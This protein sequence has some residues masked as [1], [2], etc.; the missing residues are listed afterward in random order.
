[1]LI[2]YEN[3]VETLIDTGNHW[4]DHEYY[5]RECLEKHIINKRRFTR[6]RNPKIF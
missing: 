4:I 5:I 6:I 2:S 1:M 3:G